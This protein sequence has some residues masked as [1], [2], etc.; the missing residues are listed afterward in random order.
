M[1]K[2]VGRC[3]ALLPFVL[4][5]APAWGQGESA[6]LP[7][8]DDSSAMNAPAELAWRQFAWV[9]RPADDGGALWEGWITAAEVYADPHRTPTWPVT[10]RGRVLEDEPLQLAAIRDALDQDDT[11]DDARRPGPLVGDDHAP[12]TEVRFNR[13][14]L[15]WIVQKQLWYVEGQ[16]ALYD[17]FRSGQ[18]T[19]VPFPLGSVAIKA[20]WK[21]IAEDQAARYFTHRGPAGELFGLIAMHLTTKVLPTWFWATFE[22]VDNP[23]RARVTRPDSYG[24]DP[25]D[26]SKPSSQVLQLFA[27]QGLDP[28]VWGNYRLD[29]TQTSWVDPFGRPIV[30]ANSVIETGVTARSSCMTCHVRASLGEEGKRLD[31]QPLVGAPDPAWFLTPAAPGLYDPNTWSVLGAGPTATFVPLDFLWSTAR[32]KSRTAAAPGAASGP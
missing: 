5:L 18:A 31:V 29:G 7:G 24:I 32:A 16:E 26:P 10:T 30:L 20:A 1:T 21:P 17:R 23:Y 9:N 3:A 8:L 27:D 4:T 11:P 28:A 15:D 14:V 19:T 12:K 22:H 6:P 13:T 2:N 25:V